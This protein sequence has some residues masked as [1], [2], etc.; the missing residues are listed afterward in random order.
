[1]ELQEFAPHLLISQIRLRTPVPT[2][3][4]S[5]GALIAELR[6]LLDVPEWSY[7]QDGIDVFSTDGRELFRVRSAEI[8]ASFE[9]FDDFQT[10]TA[11]T[12]SFIER[13]L[14]WLGRS[15]PR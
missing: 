4:D 6:D 13:V 12:R 3:F 11:R 7:N 14:D 15:Y 8:Y 1:M 5:R 2:F 9:N 10:A